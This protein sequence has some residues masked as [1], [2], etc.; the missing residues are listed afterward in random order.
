MAFHHRR[1][2]VESGGRPGREASRQ[3]ARAARVILHL[4]ENTR[5]T[6]TA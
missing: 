4:V 1:D 3:L 2:A 5:P 6:R